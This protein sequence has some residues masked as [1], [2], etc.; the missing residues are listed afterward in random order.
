MSRVRLC[1]TLILLLALLV[2]ANGKEAGVRKTE[3]A[4][5]GAG[6]FWC[7]EAVFQGLDGVVSVTSGYSGGRKADPTYKEVCSGNTGHAEVVRIEFDPSR[8]SY[9][10]LLEWF[11][12]MHDPTTP[13]R[14]GAD[15]GT[16]YRSVIF[17]YSDEQRKTAEQ[18]RKAAQASGVFK[19]TIVTQIE[20]AGAFYPAE[21]Y[22]QNYYGANSNAP[23]CRM[24]IEPK[25]RKLREKR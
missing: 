12:K 11:W 24:V 8:I 6:C 14:Q 17:C 16:Q 9:S 22:H 25:L 13:N 5:F 7:V 21:D 1:Q 20:E 18:S 15:V 2:G 3:F 19:G 10:A 4:M 23:Y